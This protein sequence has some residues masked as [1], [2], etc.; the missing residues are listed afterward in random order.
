M[1]L[2]DQEA[3]EAAAKAICMQDGHW[4]EQDLGMGK[5]RW[6]LYK[7]HAGASLASAANSLRERRMLIDAFGSWDDDGEYSAAT[8][9]NELEPVAIIRIEREGQS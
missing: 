6:T 3:I 2:F 7:K 4:P 9:A 1:T 5:L 8:W